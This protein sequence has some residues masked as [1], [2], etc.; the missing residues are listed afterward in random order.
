MR[1]LPP[2]GVRVR[3]LSIVLLVAAG[4]LVSSCSLVRGLFTREKEPEPTLGYVEE[5]R[6]AY[7]DRDMDALK[8]LIQIFEDEN[9]PLDVR[10][11]AVRAVGESRHPLALEALANYVQ[12]AEA[13]E[14]DLMLASIDVLGD[15]QDD[16]TASRALVESMFTID[17]KLRGLQE[18]VFKNLRNVKKEDQVLVLLDI[19][20]RS[21]ANFQRTALMVSRTLGK[22]DGRE[23]IPILIFIANDRSLDV[24]IRNRALDILSQKKDDPEVVSMFVEMLTDP[25]LESQIRDFALRTMKDVKEERLILALLES[26]TQ[27]RSSYFSLLN[28][29]VDALGNFDDP[30]VKPVL[31]EITLSQDVPRPLR[32]K[33]LRNLGNFGDPEVFARILPLL[34]EADNYVYYPYVMELAQRLGV[35]DRYKNELREA[36]LAAQE[37]ALESKKEAP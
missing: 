6:L 32:I 14:L 22:M 28:T 19:Y 27:G 16:P 31:V 17:E 23:V 1:P 2:G 21:R 35:A 10:I 20:E 36:A 24:N 8:E 18:A 26:Y 12:K 11:A 37:K 30:A 13:L 34:K 7:I 4:S 15:F 9:Q 29:L 33:A 3:I 5:L 25:S